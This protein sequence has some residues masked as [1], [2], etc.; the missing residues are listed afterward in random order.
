[1]KFEEMAK[2]SLTTLPT[3][4]YKMANLTKLLG[5]PNIYIKRDDVM[6][7]AHGGNKTRKLEYVFADALAKGADCV[8]T[9][10]GIQSNHIRQTISGAARLGIESHAI[11]NIPV[12]EIKDE[13]A[14]SGNYLLDVLMDGKLH[15]VDGD[16]D[17][18]VAKMHQV[19]DALIAE[20]KTPYLVP[21]GASDGIGSLGYMACAR[22][23]IS[24]WQAININPSH[25]FVGT[26]SC[27]THGGL[28]AGL[29]YFGNTSTQV[30]GISV[31]QIAEVKIAGVKD[32]L[33]QMSDVVKFP[34]NLI[35]DD[36]II[37]KD[38]YYGK[39]YAYPTDEANDAI[40]L[41]AKTEGVLLDP[42]Y[43]GKMMA[44]M[45][46]MIKKGDLNNA[47][48]I[49]FLHTGGAPALHPYAKYFLN[50]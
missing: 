43:T 4:F 42:V 3:S 28:L 9:M 2:V 8:I 17:D 21:M 48:D 46:D 25:I 27:G 5:Q 15:I 13:L 44:G 40:R 37:V 24:Q 16:D 6:D 10:G 34:E 38:A 36:D 35:P 1:M 23:L 18:C 7:L 20:G 31:S 22:E 39:A 29:R 32:I 11:M 47:R 33:N 45:L 30:I 49:V 41:L 19:R 12:P 14:S 26:G 50:N